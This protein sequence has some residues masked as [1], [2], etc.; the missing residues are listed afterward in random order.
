METVVDTA[1]R[2]TWQFDTTQ[3]DTKSPAWQK[4]LGKPVADASSE[5]VL[6]DDAKIRA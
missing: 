1:V 5:L 2:N 3:F 6:G 4:V